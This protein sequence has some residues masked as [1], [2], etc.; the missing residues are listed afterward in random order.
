VLV[1]HEQ[2]TGQSFVGLGTCTRIRGTKSSLLFFY[3]GARLTREGS[4][5]L[6][7]R[8]A[9]DTLPVEARLAHAPKGR[10]GA[11]ASALDRGPV[12]F[13]FNRTPVCA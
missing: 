2:Q 12:C 13:L 1:K 4:D 9:Q 3:H 8:E 11:Q 10:R 7:A 6:T 5:G